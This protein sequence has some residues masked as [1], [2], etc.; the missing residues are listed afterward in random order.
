MTT[1]FPTN[2]TIAQSAD[3]SIQVHFDAPGGEFFTVSDKG[4]TAYLQFVVRNSIGA[5]I[6]GFHKIEEACRWCETLTS[7]A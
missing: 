6:R 3:L 2:V 1:T 7:A 4:G 5:I